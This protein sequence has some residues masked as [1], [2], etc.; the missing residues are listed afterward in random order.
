MVNKKGQQWRGFDLT[1][2]Q[3]AKGSFRTS[4]L[5]NETRCYANYATLKTYF[6]LEY[7]FKLRM[8]K[9]TIGR[10]SHM[11]TYEMSFS[12]SWEKTLC[13]LTISFI[14]LWMS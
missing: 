2:K 14:Y 10:I 9:Q 7:K 6:K 12:F 13:N 8:G 1:T 4:I 11:T 3:I 5:D